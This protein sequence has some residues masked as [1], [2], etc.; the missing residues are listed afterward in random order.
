MAAFVEADRLKIGRSPGPRCSL[1]ECLVRERPAVGPA[2][3]EAAAA[4]A[5]EPV[6]EQVLRRAA[7]TGTVRRPERLCMHR[8]HSLTFD[9]GSR[10]V[11]DRAWAFVKRSM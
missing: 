3:E 2:E 10:E 1:A 7:G 9:S 4:P 5:G 8:G 6:L 11:A